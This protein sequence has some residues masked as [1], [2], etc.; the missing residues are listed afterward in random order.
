MEL[1]RLIVLLVSIALAGCTHTDGKSNW[2]PVGDFVEGVVGQSRNG[3]P[4]TG[5]QSV[6]YRDQFHRIDFMY[7]LDPE[8][9]R[10]QVCP[11]L[12]DRSTREVNTTI[13]EW[14]AEKK[15][16]VKV[17]RK[18]RNRHAEDRI[19]TNR[20]VQCAF[21]AFY[22]YSESC[23]RGDAVDFEQGQTD[24]ISR[25]VCLEQSR[26]TFSGETARQAAKNMALIIRRNQVQDKILA[27]SENVCRKF[28]IELNDQVTKSNFAFGS[29]AA[30]VGGLA[31]IFT[32]PTTVRSLAGAASIVSGIGAEY[33]NAYLQGLTVHVI[34]KGIDARREEILEEINGHRYGPPFLESA[35]EVEYFGKLRV[36][37]NLN[38]FDEN[39]AIVDC[40]LDVLEKRIQLAKKQ[41]DLLDTAGGSSRAKAVRYASRPYIPLSPNDK[42]NLALQEEFNRELS[43][44]KRKVRLLNNEVNEIKGKIAKID[45]DA[46]AAAQRSVQAV[47]RAKAEAE[48][49]IAAVSKQ[50]ERQSALVDSL[51]R[52]IDA[53]S[54]A[55]LKRQGD[56]TLHGQLTKQR[57]DADIEL[58][59]L[60]QSKIRLIGNA[61]QADLI[62]EG[63]EIDDC[64][65][66]EHQSKTICRN[67][68]SDI[69]ARGGVCAS[70]SIAEGDQA[71]C[72]AFEKL[73]H[74]QALQCVPGSNLS[75]ELQTHCKAAGLFADGDPVLKKT[76]GDPIVDC[77]D[78]SV[79]NEAQCTALK[80][81]IAAQ[82]PICTANPIAAADKPK[83]D[84]FN[85]LSPQQRL[86]CVPQQGASD[87]EKMQCVKAE[88]FAADAAPV[89]TAPKE[90]KSCA[91]DA[92]EE[93][94]CAAPL[95]KLKA[96]GGECALPFKLN[97]DRVK[98]GAFHELAS[99]ERLKCA[100]GTKLSSTKRTSCLI[101]Q[102]LKRT[103]VASGAGAVAVANG[104]ERESLENELASKEAEANKLNM[105]I[106]TLEELF[107]GELAK[108]DAI[109]GMVPISQYTVER[110]VQDSLRYHAACTIP[111]GLEQASD[112]V[113]K[114]RAPGF[115][116]VEQ[117]LDNMINIRKKLNDL[118]ELY[119]ERRRLDSEDE[120]LRRS[121]AEA[122]AN[123]SDQ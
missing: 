106:A 27:V 122:E 40:E 12:P 70:V 107:G 101:A 98:C 97:A 39:G 34:T 32:D 17:K 56:R 38:C 64:A 89:F 41:K 93:Q 65:E 104:E 46:A 26:W 55:G 37:V 87:A 11:G 99:A 52:Q 13:T 54:D 59:A 80:A 74:D 35:Q 53:L 4:R 95:A 2:G 83:C 8:D 96:L 102:L 85:A 76:K 113:E 14:S 100:P 92:Q 42:V 21:A 33:N 49:E 90:I 50:I 63:A 79:K 91:G 48:T 43:D 29:T 88:L 45:A 77:A 5:S 120:S 31:T 108:V 20:E 47:A 62:V 68:I 81:A 109:V 36:P 75:D 114:I 71:K 117:G 94:A 6:T 123:Q 121:E 1:K 78:D 86:K 67:L 69:A 24:A 44:K 57:N 118:D 112:S 60:Q 115:D 61:R 18:T 19:T 10:F 66:D 3:D 23:P 7:L 119:R 25:A 84:A 72:E 110:A 9:R 30:I 103:T 28:K 58:G 16:W 73:K 22:T 116:T 105:R 82:I 51:N 15:A 111:A